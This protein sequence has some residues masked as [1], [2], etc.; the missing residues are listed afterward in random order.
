MD[1]HN[2][3]LRAAAQEAL[4]EEQLVLIVAEEQRAWTI[5]RELLEGFGF[6]HF[7]LHFHR[8]RL[9]MEGPWEEEISTDDQ[10]EFRGSSIPVDSS[11]TRPSSQPRAL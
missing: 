1:E 9:G 2:E 7:D 3:R 11:T 10:W 4:S 8:Y 6:Q 5:G